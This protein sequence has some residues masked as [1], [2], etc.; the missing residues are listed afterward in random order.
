MTVNKQDSYTLAAGVADRRT[1]GSTERALTVVGGG[2]LVAYGLARRDISGAVLAALGGALLYQ[3]VEGQDRVAPLL[4]L[5]TAEQGGVAGIKIEK[6]IMIEQPAEELYRFWRNFENLPRFMQHLESVQVSGER[7]SHWVAKAPANT[8][9]AWDAD[10]TDERENEYIAW[11]SVEGSQV[12]NAG[13][14]RFIPIAGRGTEV[15]VSMVYD[16]PAGSVGVIVAKLFGEEP[17][18]QVD[19]DL[20]RFKSLMEA[21][22]IPTVEGQSSGRTAEVEKQRKELHSVAEKLNQTPTKPNQL[23]THSPMNKA[24]E[25]T[26]PASDPPSTTQTPEDGAGVTNTER[27]VGLGKRIY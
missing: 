11:R 17:S 14:V 2:A 15:Q 16:P 1:L 4:G 13:E 22:E 6:R 19:G 23:G 3:G 7:H 25:D 27:E 12:M 18:Q 10:I 20:R 9:V 26:F 24:L 5:K 21:G 8:T